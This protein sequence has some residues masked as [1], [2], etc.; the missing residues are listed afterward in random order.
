M[1]IALI[2]GSPKPKD[3]ASGILLSELEK[4]KI[5]GAV[6][7]HFAVNKPCVGKEIIEKII[8][9]DVLVFAFPLY[10]DGIPSH[11]LN[12]L[13]EIENAGIKNKKIRVYGISNCGFF[14]GTQ[15]EIA[16]GILKNWCNKTGFQWGMAVG[17]G[18]G[19]AMSQFGEEKPKG[20]IKSLLSGLE[21][22]KDSIETGKT[23]E[24]V[25]VSIN[26]PRWLYKTAAEIGWKQ[27]IKRNGGKPSDLNQKY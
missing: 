26:F 17:F 4:C 9:H 21:K 14:E 1:K 7:S 3:S 19:G 10:V 27:L 18:G 24:N 25:Y 11:L 2:N 23:A 22:M 8:Q 20:M 6:F 13:K 15:N 16:L 5:Q 12:C